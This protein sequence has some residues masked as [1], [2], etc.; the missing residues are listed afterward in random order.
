[1]TYLRNKELEEAIFLDGLQLA[2]AQVGA[3]R[4]LIHTITQ[5]PLADASQQVLS[6][7]THRALDLH[8]TAMLLAQNHPCQTGARIALRALVETVAEV[9][10]ILAEDTDIRA[11]QFIRHQLA[12]DKRLAEAV[13][14]NERGIPYST[15][16]RRIV[17]SVR[18]TRT[19][20]SAG[21]DFRATRQAAHWS[22]LGIEAVFNAT[23]ISDFYRFS[24]VPLSAS[25]HSSWHD[26]IKNRLHRDD[27]GQV[28]LNDSV[29]EPLCVQLIHG[30]VFQSAILLPDLY[31]FFKFESEALQPQEMVIAAIREQIERHEQAMATERGEEWVQPKDNEPA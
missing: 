6:G 22:G 21:E 3:Y 17:S 15:I 12:F 10:W 24:Y 2:D 25:V 30:I 13:Y 8:M 9:H 29:G 20:H 28:W 26:F 5:K 14:Q 1:M 4:A 27:N 11:H 23:G 18:N 7:F 31:T 16:G 19:Q